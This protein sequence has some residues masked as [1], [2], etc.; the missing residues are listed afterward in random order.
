MKKRLE[1]GG[2]KGRVGGGL[3]RTGGRPMGGRGG[4]E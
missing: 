1:V 2:A 4:A 3:V